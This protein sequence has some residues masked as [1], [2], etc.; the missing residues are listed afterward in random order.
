MP[1]FTNLR[2]QGPHP[3]P[4]W[5]RVGTRIQPRDGWHPMHTDAAYGVIRKVED[6][7]IVISVYNTHHVT[8]GCVNLWRKDQGTWWDEGSYTEIIAPT[9]WE[10][11]LR[12]DDPV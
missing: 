6:G 4:A 2:P 11:L 3:L 9:A 1:V 10:R 5:A 12:D 7:I 8:H